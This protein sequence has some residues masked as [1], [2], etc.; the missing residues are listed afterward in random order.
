MGSALVGT[1]FDRKVC[2]SGDEEREQRRYLLR[3]AQLQSK[4]G[5]RILPIMTQPRTGPLPD[6]VPASPAI[7]DHLRKA[8]LN[9]PFPSSGYFVAISSF[10]GDSNLPLVPSTM[11]VQSFEGNPTSFTFTPP[12]TLWDTA[13]H[14]C[15]ITEDCLDRGFVEYLKDPENEF[16]ELAG[17]VQVDATIVLSEQICYISFL[18]FV[19]PAGTL[20]NNFSGVLLGQY[21]FLDQLHYEMIPEKLLHAYGAP[22]EENMWGI[23]QLHAMLQADNSLKEFSSPDRDEA[24][25]LPEVEPVD[26]EENMVDAFSNT[27]PASHSNGQSHS[28][29]S[30]TYRPDSAGG[31]VGL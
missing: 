6:P 18:A 16:P 22:V 28:E 31:E 24:G 27:E 3:A 9:A 7:R 12:L 30:P 29:K 5:P 26:P 8:A 14:S 2:L 25:A 1:E 11:N 4:G 19:V 17:K 21:T 10:F 23:I 15:Q 13:S 20:P